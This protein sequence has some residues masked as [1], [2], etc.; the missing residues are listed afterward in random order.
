MQ[1]HIPRLSTLS[2][3]VGLHLEVSFGMQASWTAV[4]RL[5][6]G[7][8]ISTLS[9]LP[10]HGFGTMEGVLALHIL[11]QPQVALF[12][13]LLGHADGSIHDGNLLE[14]LIFG[15]IGKHG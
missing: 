7:E 9:A 14:A 5:L 12:V 2:V 13:L 8:C 4:G 1:H 3:V 11:Q 10:C 6:A 15:Y